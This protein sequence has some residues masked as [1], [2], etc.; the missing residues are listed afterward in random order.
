MEKIREIENNDLMKR[1]LKDSFGGVMFNISEGATDKYSTND[2][3]ELYCL[4][5]DLK[6]YEKERLN[7]AL[8]GAINF[9]KQIL[10]IREKL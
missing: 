5:N 8:I 2:L 6:G 9:V 1:I 10:E 4:Y 7:G 3:K